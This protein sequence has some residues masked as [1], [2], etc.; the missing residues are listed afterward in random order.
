MPLSQKRAKS[1]RSS[2]AE[3]MD[4]KRSCLFTRKGRGAGK[5]TGLEGG[6]RKGHCLTWVGKA[7]KA[8][9]CPKCGHSTLGEKVTRAGRGEPGSSPHPPLRKRKT[10]A[11]FRDGQ[12]ICSSS[13]RQ[14]KDRG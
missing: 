11:T 2:E 14:D 7:S 5:P 6:G 1:G 10:L 9:T 4:K 12:S 3:G 13:T 8:S